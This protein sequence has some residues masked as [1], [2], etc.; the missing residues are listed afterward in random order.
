MLSHGQELQVILTLLAKEDAIDL[1][2]REIAYLAGVALGTVS[3]TINDLRQLGY[4]RKY[5]HKLKIMN[6]EK[7]VFKW[8][9]E[10]P[11]KIRPKLNPRRSMFKIDTGGSKRIL[12]DMEPFLVAKLQQESLQNTC[13]QK[14]C[15]LCT[16]RNQ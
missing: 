8:L 7:L 5:K 1:T 16:G 6:K 2:Y 11:A 13:I 12:R 15:A 4:I 3:W 10:Y 9:E 14:R